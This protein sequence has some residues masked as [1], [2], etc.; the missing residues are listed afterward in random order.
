MTWYFILLF[1]LGALALTLSALWLF[2]IAPRA[3]KKEMAPFL[4]P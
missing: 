1:V 2:L 3:K 4:R